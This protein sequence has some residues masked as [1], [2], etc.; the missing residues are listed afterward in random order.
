MPKIKVAGAVA[1]HLETIPFMRNAM[2]DLPSLD[3]RPL[4]AQGV[5][6]L[7]RVVECAQTVASGNI[8]VLEAPFN[9]LP[10]RRVL[11]QMGFSSTADKLDEKHWRIDC[12]RDGNGH[13]A[14]PVTDED[15]QGLPDLGAPIHRDVDGVH[16]D[17]RAMTAPRPMLAILRLCAAVPPGTDIIVHHERDPIYLYP[18]LA[19]LGWEIASLP[20][21]PGEVRLRLRRAP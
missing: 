12:R 9:P 19:E 11:A 21:E 20:G 7:Q 3:L 8:L 16:I 2:T 18:E 17:V 13:V 1:R 5:D 10:L 4:L 6:P 15:C 14:G